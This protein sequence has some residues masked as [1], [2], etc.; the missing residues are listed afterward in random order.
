MNY[1]ELLGMPGSGKSYTANLIKRNSKNKRFHD[2]RYI[3]I[4]YFFDTEKYN[5]FT[6]FKILFLLILN[7]NF[8]INLKP[9]IR[10]SGEIYNLNNKIRFKRSKRSIMLKFLDLF[11]LDKQ[12]L[13]LLQ[14]LSIKFKIN[15]KNI[16]KILNQEI[17]KLD[18]K[19]FFKKKLS[20]WVLENLILIEILN[21]KN[22][23]N[24]IVDE[25]LLQR[26][27]II[28][29]LTTKKEKFMKNILIN[30]KPYGKIIICNTSLNKIFHRSSKRKSNMDGYYYNNIKKIKKEKNNFEIFKKKILKKIKFK[31]KYN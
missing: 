23:F 22:N 8:I 27:Y 18:Q 26:I 2:L 24:C 12:Y 13:S 31:E 15:K 16:Y 9:Q 29:S 3:I 17:Q 6:K 7:S 4:K 5:F 25:G 19:N 28:F 1:Y 11:N 21:I 14:S 10:K 20:R 30:Y